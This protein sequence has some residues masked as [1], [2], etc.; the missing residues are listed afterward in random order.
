MGGEDGRCET[1]DTLSSFVHLVLGGGK[2][3]LLAGTPACPMFVGE[4]LFGKLK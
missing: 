3:K 2:E 1:R 4:D